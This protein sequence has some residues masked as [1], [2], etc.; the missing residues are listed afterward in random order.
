M[1]YDCNMLGQ[2][3]VGDGWSTENVT[4]SGNMFYQCWSLVGGAGTRFDD[5]HTDAGYAHVNGGTENP[6]YLTMKPKWLR[7]DVNLDG[8]IDV[9][10]IASVISV[11]ASSTDPQSSGGTPADVNSDG[12]V[13][14][15]DI[16]SII[17]IMAANSRCQVIED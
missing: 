17:S 3:S 5:D 6:G 11:M 1:F 16:A 8:V 7:G 9:A 14:V 10:D 12:S 2:I 15:A 13:D 4:A